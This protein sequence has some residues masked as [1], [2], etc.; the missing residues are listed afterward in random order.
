MDITEDILTG[1]KALFELQNVLW[2][3]HRGTVRWRNMILGCL[4][5]NNSEGSWIESFHKHKLGSTFSFFCRPKWMFSGLKK[6]QAKRQ[7]KLQSAKGEKCI[8]WI[9][10][11]FHGSLIKAINVHS[12]ISYNYSCFM[13]SD[14]FRW[15]SLMLFKIYT[16]MCILPKNF[17]LVI[18]CKRC[19]CQT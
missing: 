14:V 16:L 4:V 7:R 10:G 8:L 3:S 1:A 11:A 13:Q 6:I 2:C 15:D 9:Y 5:L 19:K 18:T 12:M 17:I